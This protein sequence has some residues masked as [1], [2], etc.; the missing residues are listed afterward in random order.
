MPSA[1][2]GVGAVAAAAEERKKRKYSHLDQC[3][4]FV[5]VAIETTGGFGPETM[6]FLQELGRHLQLVS[7][8]HNSTSYLIQRLSVAVQRGNAASVLG[9]TGNMDRHDFFEGP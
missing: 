7:A 5:P 3:H 1:A 6:E 8:D 9:S 4:L 2:S